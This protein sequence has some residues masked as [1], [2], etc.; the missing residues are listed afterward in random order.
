[1][2]GLPATL[3][4]VIEMSGARSTASDV[5]RCVASNVRYFREELGLSQ[6]EL[7]QR[8]SE[9]GF[10]FTQATIW[11]IESCQRE[12]RISEGVALCAA[13]NLL[14]GP[15]SRGIRRSVGLLP[16]SDRRTAG[17]IRRTPRFMRR[18]RGTSKSRSAW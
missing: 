14:A 8:M 15:T 6:K 13:L 4:E 11:K 17:R 10:G 12:V 18:R 9:R 1:M 5:D 2:T 16:S 3:F 7:A